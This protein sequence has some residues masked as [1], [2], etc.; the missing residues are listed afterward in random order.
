MAN[1]QI[2]YDRGT[3]PVT[4]SLQRGPGRLPAYEIAQ[5]RKDNVSSAGV[6]EAIA[7]RQDSFLE[8]AME[9]VG[10]GADVQ[11]WAAFMQYALKGGAFSYYP[12]ASQSAFT[13]YWLE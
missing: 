10:T 8:L 7:L 5:E 6:R 12:D 4:F 2:I 3:G 9:W 13:N 1:Q 11:A